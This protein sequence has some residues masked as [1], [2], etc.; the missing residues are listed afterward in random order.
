[1][2]KRIKSTQV[3]LGSDSKLKEIL[4]VQNTDNPFEDPAESEK[5]FRNIMEEEMNLSNDLSYE[6]LNRL[7]NLYFKG[8]NLYE[9]TLNFEKVDLLQEK[10]NFVL[11]LTK[12][13]KILNENKA[14]S[15]NTKKSLGIND[16]KVKFKINSNNIENEDKTETK[17]NFD[18]RKCRTLRNNEIGNKNR[19]NHISNYIKMNETKVQKEKIDEIHKEYN[20]LNEELKKTSSFLK[21]EIEKQTNNFK[22]KLFRKR[23]LRSKNNFKYKITTIQ[24]ENAENDN[25]FPLDK[26]SI[27]QNGFRIIK[28]KT[29]K[30]LKSTN[31]LL[32]KPEQKEFDDLKRK[33]FRNLK[34]IKKSTNNNEK[35]VEKNNIKETQSTKSITIEKDNIKEKFNQYLGEYN[36]DIYKYYYIQILN[37]ITD[38]SKKQFLNNIKIYQGY[39]DNIND[40]LRKQ[41]SC[42]DK[43]EE[44]ILEDDINSL[45]EEQEHEIQKTND[46]YEKYIEEEIS[47]FKI[48]GYSTATVKELDILKNKIK[49][50]LYNEVYNILNKRG[51]LK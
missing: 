25:N 27:T 8:L 17:T 24:E 34:K 18:F 21:D 43:E 16:R 4:F 10:I 28:S 7:L 45:K 49:C 19:Y 31:I 44:Q 48:F 40:L 35:K 13:K 47:N 15:L 50:D 51:T 23:T 30:N 1:M 33:S 38:L 20:S 29:P 39:Q 42:N 5:F 46:L 11:N 26:K 36:N 22:E 32:E 14:K 3:G 6:N 37:N 12:V 9:K 2:Q 41:L